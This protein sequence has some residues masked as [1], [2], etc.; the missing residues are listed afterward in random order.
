MVNQMN[1]EADI[2]KELDQFYKTSIKQIQQD[3]IVL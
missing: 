2:F 3:E 1:D